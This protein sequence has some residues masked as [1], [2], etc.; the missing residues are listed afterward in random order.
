MLTA[1]S[2]NRVS[3]SSP[4]VCTT[5]TRRAC[6]TQLGALSASTVKGM[7][8]RLVFLVGSRAMQMLLVCEPHFENH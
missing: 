3:G 5:V 6:T 2:S 8:Q 4:V 7:R 1:L